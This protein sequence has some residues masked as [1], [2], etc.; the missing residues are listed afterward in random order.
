MA[1]QIKSEE[2]VE[3]DVFD[4][5]ERS[6]ESLLVVLNAIEVQFKDILKIS[7]QFIKSSS[8]KNAKDFKNLEDNLV[9]VKKATE[10]LDK[11]ETERLKLLDRLKV[12]NSDRI[13]TNVQ[14]KLLLQEQSTINKRIEREKL[15][16]LGLLKKTD[17]EKK[18]EIKTAKQLRK[19]TIDNANAFKRLTKQT[20]NAQARFKRLAAQFGE[21][22]DR[23]IKALKTFRKLDDRLRKINDTARDG[24]R[25]VGR[26]GIAIRELGADLKTLFVAGGVVGVI[27]GL[28][29]AIGNSFDRIRE[30]DK[31]LNNF[32]GIAGKT[33]KELKDVERV[34]IRVAGESTRTSNEVAK[35]ATVLVS[36]GKTEREIKLLLKPVND[37]SIALNSTS[38]ETAD[39]L[40][41]T[42]NAFGK[43]ADSAQE[44]ADIISNI[45]TSTSLDFQRIKDALGFVAPTANALGLSLGQ[46]GAQLG[47][48]QDNG[49]RAARAGRLLSTSFL[50]LAKN[51]RSLDGALDDI[52]KA[53]EEGVS[54]LELLRITGELF[55][56]ESAALGIVLANNRD[57]VAELSNEFDNL[58]EG[59]LKE[60][61]D[62]QLESLDAQ[63]KI[64]DSTFERFLLSVENGEGVISRFVK[65]SI[66]EIIKLVEGFRRL[67]QS[68][69][70]N[71]DEDT[72][73]ATKNLEKKIRKNAKR[74]ITLFKKE[75]EDELKIFK[76]ALDDKKISQQNFD[77]RKLASAKKVSDI[78]KTAVKDAIQIQIGLEKRRRERL[79]NEREFTD[80][81]I[82]NA[83]RII[84]INQPIA[85]LIEL[86]SRERKRE[87]AGRIQVQTA[88][89]KALEA[90]LL[91]E[92]EI[93][94][95]EKENNEIVLDGGKKKRVLTGLIEKQAKVVSDLT[96]EIKRAKEEGLV[97]ELSIELDTAQRELD[98]LRRIATSSIE[99][100]DK[101][102]R[103][104]IE[105]ASERRIAQ[106]IAKSEKLVQQIISNSKIETELKEKLII[107][108]NAR[109]GKF[110]DN[111][112]IK[113]GKARIKRN[114][115][116]AKA[117]FEQRRTGF[118][119]EKQF[120]EEKEEQFLAIKK[121]ALEDE[122]KLLEQFGDDST[123]V[124]EE[125]I[126]SELESL[127]NFNEQLIINTE[128]ATE[129]L[130]EILEKRTNDR[131]EAIDKEIAAERGRISD[132][133]KL[134][135]DG[136]EE[137]SKSLAFEQKREAELQLK[138][139]DAL[140]RK[141]QQEL[142]IT[143]IEIY[144]Q[145]V[146]AG[147]E[148]P[149]GST[150][151][152][153]TL[154]KQFISSLPSFY[155]GIESTGR[156][157]L[158]SKGAFLSLLHPK[159]RVLN[160]VNN[161]PWN[162][163]SNNEMGDIGHKLKAGTL[164]DMSKYN[165]IEPSVL[166]PDR[167]IDIKA[168]EEI[169]KSILEIP[170]QMP[171]HRMYYDDVLRII[172]MATKSNGK[173]EREHRRFDS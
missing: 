116:L 130:R 149:L 21:N 153:I 170:K 22:D 18:K 64:L 93:N 20:N 96:E 142:A 66:T 19:A 7:E 114:E 123:K 78:E 71:I 38:E 54:K 151:S 40:G 140:K 61:T 173:L 172:T 157:S 129:I 89:I 134:A 99:E 58:S 51:G 10:G 169:N 47:V 49:I 32:A 115:E 69:I 44:F 28:G 15:I 76:K 150:I 101:I 56:A 155:E 63:F 50:R 14:I 60:L 37:L 35:L 168:L 165:Q 73:I 11:V 85:G 52:N 94:V 161:D 104:L 29:R 48:L 65:N 74:L 88:R 164:M 42:L 167:G 17:A 103:D 75:Q 3:K 146:S 124:R 121:K 110:I 70:E 23:T 128:D 57:R 80:I 171:D 139:E 100:A 160:E 90:L 24:R 68:S 131:I 108:E 154:L 87:E 133:K 105:N 102:E 26:Y 77:V 125:Q 118:K 120:E 147:E 25:D 82:E 119:T 34:I 33:R 111:E 112:E 9:K 83:K 59:G 46:I 72:E 67:N 166:I 43:S 31:E 16:E 95:V 117:E 81:T 5:S 159:E 113:Q 12:A 36:L 6:G 79:L 141:E 152:D 158:D 84:E 138:R 106:E 55:G 137:A 62:Q 13:Q 39:F 132:L 97:L 1:K 144:G 27:R 98:R 2:I 107:A 136:D 122:L 145:K 109:L 86:N 53:Q 126:K 45:R 148:N 8:P 162:G 135:D 30:F 156:G 163:V 143:A 91:I 41:Q 4:N 127:N 92:K